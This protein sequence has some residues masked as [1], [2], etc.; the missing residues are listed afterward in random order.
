[1]VKAELK[2][3]RAKY[4]AKA[5]TLASVLKE[6]ATKSGEDQTVD[7]DLSKTTKLGE[8][9]ASIK[10]GNLRKMRE[11]V[12]DLG[13]QLDLLNEINRAEHSGDEFKSMPIPEGAKGARAMQK[14]FGQMFV[15]SDA[16]TR[17]D[18]KAVAGIDIELKTLFETTAGWEP[19]SIR[20]GRVVLS[21]QR[22]PQVMDLIPMTNTNSA[23]LT[24]MEETTF[25]NTAAETAEGGTYPEATLELTERTVPIRKIAVWIPVTDEQLEDAAQAASYVESRLR[26]MIEQRL[27]EQII[28]GNG[29]APNIEGILDRTGIQTATIAASDDSRQDAIF[30][31]MTLVRT[32]GLASPN[33]V[34]MNPT[35]WQTLR[36]ARDATSGQYL[37]GPP[38]QAGLAQVW[39][40]PVVL[41]NEMASEVSLVGDFANFSA[42]A[43][44]RG[45]D[46]QITNS[47]SDFFINGKQAIRADI[48]VGLAVYRPAAFAEIVQ[49]T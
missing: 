41:F 45:I 17:R 8:G 37:W 21:A 44:R 19:E 4:Q 27:D 10:L 46:V 2:E 26:F 39:G 1:M 33:A 6:C 23:A 38:S 20:S 7:Y 18:Q 49:G 9:D 25:T 24:Y 47:H 31:A 36:L 22:G 11:E 42:L 35:D 15:E 40:L 12:D 29:I 30:R 43:M 32:N 14:T 13:K 3:V 48:R 16:Y 5:E 28:S 34:V